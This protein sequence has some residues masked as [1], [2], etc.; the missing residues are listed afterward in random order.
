MS[1]NRQVI[2]V[3]EDTAIVIKAHGNLDVKGTPEW[4]ISI[5]TDIN[6]QKIR[7]EGDML[8]LLFVEDCDLTVPQNSKVII[9]RTGE[10]A[11]I[12]DINQMIEIYKVSGDLALQNTGKVT[13]SRIGGDCLLEKVNDELT[14]EKIY[15]D[16]KGFGVAGQ[17]QI[18]KVG[19]DVNLFGVSAGARIKAN[20]DI[21][22]G[23]SGSSSE[24]VYLRAGDDIELSLPVEPNASLTVK[25]REEKIS[26]DLAERTEKIRVKNSEFILGEGSQ[27]IELDASGKV[28]ITSKQFDDTE[29][30]HLFEELDNLWKQLKTQSEARRETH[31]HSTRWD[32]DL[33]VGVSKITSEALDELSVFSDKKLMETLN[34]AENRVQ[35][36]LRKVEKKIRELGYEDLGVV[37]PMENN[38]PPK[39]AE[40]TAE[41][42]LVIMR[43]LQEG[44]ISV[45]EADKLLEALETDAY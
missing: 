11:R 27:K 45:E 28:D 34:T 10:N 22:L 35:E 33:V 38:K 42:R 6:V 13:V 2:S 31:A 20:G 24:E 1:K 18:E 36:A 40:V 26:I 9:E 14:I 15:G 30:L 32:E 3:G 4:E 44:K 25:S 7:H 39:P 17:I 37:R 12:R 21:R 23:L 16:L 29:V 8:R 19:G 43:M 41:E 5:S